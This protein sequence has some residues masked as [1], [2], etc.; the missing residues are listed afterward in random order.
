MDNMAANPSGSATAKSIDALVTPTLLLDRGRLGRNIQR[1]SDRARKLGV[2]LRP[3]MKTA[4]SVDVARDVFPP[5]TRSD[6]GLDDRRGGVFRG[7]RLSRHHL[8]GRH[9]AGFGQA[10]LGALSP[11]RR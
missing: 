7:P 1:L 9:L 4:K 10:R 5:R 6:H 2:V 11:Y 8:R 3:H